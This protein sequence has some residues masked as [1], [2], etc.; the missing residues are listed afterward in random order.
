MPLSGFAT[1]YFLPGSTTAYGEKFDADAMT[2][3]MTPDRAGKN[4][5]VKVW[6]ADDPNR[7]VL[8]RVNDTGPFARDPFGG[9][10]RPLRPDPEII[11][12]LT[13]RAFVSLT[14]DINQGKVR[15]NLV[16]S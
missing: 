2:A 4:A 9:P 8:V 11:I 6:L 16:V 15:V 14:G 3:A 12:D 7:A 5:K 13:P 1:Y 10:L